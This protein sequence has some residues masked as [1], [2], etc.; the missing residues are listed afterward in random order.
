MRS[1]SSCN[2]QEFEVPRTLLAFDDGLQRYQSGPLKS[3]E[4]VRLTFF[5]G[6][7]ANRVAFHHRLLS[8]CC[9]HAFRLGRF[10]VKVIAEARH[11]N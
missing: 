2:G 7:F 9:G 6:Y 1:R 8:P 3:D 11:S 4:V 5:F 10:D